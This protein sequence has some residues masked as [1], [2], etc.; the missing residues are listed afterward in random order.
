MLKDISGKITIIFIGIL[1]FYGNSATAADVCVNAAENSSISLSCP[2]GQ[3]ISKVVFAGYGKAPSGSCGAYRASTSCNSSK[4]LSVVKAA[5]VI[6]KSSCRIAA[7][8]DVFGDPCVGTVKKLYVDVQCSAAVATPA[9][10]P[11]ASCK[12]S[13]FVGA[14]LS[15]SKVAAGGKFNVYCDYGAQNNALATTYMDAP[16]AATCV[17]NDFISGPNGVTKGQF[18]CVAGSTP[19]TYAITC[20][21]RNISPDFYCAKTNA[22]GSITIGGASA[23]PTP[24]ATPPPSSGGG[25]YG[26]SPVPVSAACP[27][28]SFTAPALV[29][30]GRSRESARS[31][32]LRRE[33][34]R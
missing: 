26:S 24:T 30:Q 3:T 12:T 28:T 23:T 27:R 15:V 16:G 19:G 9:P 13:N 25:T 22:A 5:C 29:D 2:E 10:V 32:S 31:E 1:G 14:S 33:V 21:L 20:G 34:R 6:G 18:D 17:W 7:N 4:S 11:V 8:N